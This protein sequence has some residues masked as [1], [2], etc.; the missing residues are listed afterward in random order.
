MDEVTSLTIVPLAMHAPRSQLKICRLK[1]IGSLRNVSLLD[2]FCIGLVLFFVR[3]SLQHTSTIVVRWR[4]GQWKQ[5]SI[6]G[7][8]TIGMTV[9]S[10]SIA[11][12]KSFSSFAASV[13]ADSSTTPPAGDSR[14]APQYSNFIASRM[15]SPTDGFPSRALKI[16]RLRI[17]TIERLAT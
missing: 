7:I 10:K 8:P 1:S 6:H 13:D 3:R 11:A 17:T 15:K 5:I 16:G 12:R 9:R 14:F 2:P 4:M